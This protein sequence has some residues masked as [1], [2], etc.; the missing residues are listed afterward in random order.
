KVKD[1][2]DTYVAL[3]HA[4][5]AAGRNKDAQSYFE[6]GC[7][8]KGASALPFLKLGDFLIGQ[9]LWDKAANAFRQAGD[10]DRGNPLP[11]YLQGWAL[12]KAGKSD[13]GKKLI[14]ISHWTPLGNS[15]KRLLFE[16][17]LKRRGFHND[18]RRE[19]ELVLRVDDVP[20]R[21]TAIALER[22][23]NEALAR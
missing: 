12:I 13:E 22:E 11:L 15:D 5:Q 4:C 6:K 16:Q 9:E 2:E 3:A 14:E 8:L 23:A 19:L 7:A 18:A 21:Y 1:R 10:H 20:S 17:E